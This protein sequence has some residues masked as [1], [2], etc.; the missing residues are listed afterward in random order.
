MIVLMTI[1]ISCESEKSKETKVYSDFYNDHPEN[2]VVHK[3][4]FE[5]HDYLNFTTKYGTMHDAYSGWVHDPNCK[6]CKNDSI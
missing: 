6:T 5:G 3:F 1:F 2:I 4:T